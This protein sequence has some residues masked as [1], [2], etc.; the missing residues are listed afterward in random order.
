MLGRKAARRDVGERFPLA[1]DRVAI[2]S[3]TRPASRSGSNSPGDNRALCVATAVELIT[4][5]SPA[6]GSLRP[7]T[8]DDFHRERL[9]WTVER[10]DRCETS[11][12]KSHSPSSTPTK[13]THREP[14]L[15][16]SSLKDVHALRRRPPADGIDR[17][18]SIMRFA[19]A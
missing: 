8:I 2:R 12:G 13:N 9:A 14:V 4:R 11:S 7:W 5:S 15:R 6:I 19:V 17:D 10:V 3:R 1:S 16:A 18:R